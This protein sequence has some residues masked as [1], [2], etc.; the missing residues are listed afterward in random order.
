[1]KVAWLNR[2]AIRFD[3]FL[4]VAERLQ[5]PRF[6]LAA[7]FTVY[8]LITVL[9]IFFESLGLTLLVSVLVS[10]DISLATKIV[11]SIGVSPQNSGV[12]GTFLVIAILLCLR[13]T[14]YFVILSL[15]GL[16]AARLRRRLQEK[17]FFN[18]LTFDWAETRFWRLGELVA[19]D[20]VRVVGVE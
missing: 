1:M 18:H 14:F 5:L 13:M 4:F 19:V 8:Y 15:D 9:N 10:G 11:N 2:G 16:I 20:C 3:E 7:F 6:K 12:N 17:I